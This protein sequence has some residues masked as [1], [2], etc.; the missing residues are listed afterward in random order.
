MAIRLIVA[1]RVYV[2]LLETLGMVTFFQ[3]N[4]QLIFWAHAVVPSQVIFVFLPLYF[5]PC[6]CRHYF[7]YLPLEH[8]VTHTS[9]KTTFTLRIK[10]TKGKT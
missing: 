8:L 6:V 9:L 3:H 2:L 10:S 7:T 5:A 1:L 4:K